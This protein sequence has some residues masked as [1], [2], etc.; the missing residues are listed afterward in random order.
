MGFLN[1]LWKKAKENIGKILES[2]GRVTRIEPLESAGRNLRLQSNPAEKK[3]D[4]TDERNYQTSDVID[5][6]SRCEAVRKEAEAKS[7]DLEQQCID[8]I[9]DD[10]RQ[11][12]QKLEELFPEDAFRSFD[13]EIGD[14]FTQDIHS[15]ISAYVAQ[16]ISQ[17]NLEFLEILKKGDATRKQECQE[18]LSKVM[19]QAQDQLRY[20]CYSTK[21]ELYRRMHAAIN[22]YLDSQS[23]YIRDY[24]EKLT[25]LLDKHKHAAAQQEQI[26]H[27]LAEGEH[28]RCICSLAQ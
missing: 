10:V 8:S 22:D 18:Y 2:I 1:S 28:M 16:K 9:K 20:K 6:H 25:H 26:V 12:R 17:D 27:S 13:Y 21:I 19:T 11:Y 7:S 3:V 14:D 4:M 15:T 24:E 5:L 23:E